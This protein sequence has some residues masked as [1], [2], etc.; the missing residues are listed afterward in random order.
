MLDAELPEIIAFLRGTGSG[1]DLG[2]DVLGDVYRRKSNS[3]RRGVDEDL[4]ARA[5]PP[6]LHQGVPCCLIGH[7]AAR[8]LLQREIAW[9]RPGK[10]GRD[11]DI[12]L[13]APFAK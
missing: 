7:Q 3:S 9:N 5:H 6:Q 13:K 10:S 12:S 2:A 1:E 8:R 4:V 11:G